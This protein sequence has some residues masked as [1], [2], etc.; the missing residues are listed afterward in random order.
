MH[1]YKL[2]C[3]FRELDLTGACERIIC[4]GTIT[5][6]RAVA[7]RSPDV[8]VGAGEL[9]TLTVPNTEPPAPERG[10]VFLEVTPAS[11]SC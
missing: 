11:A 4:Y 7:M 3:F 2:P 6:R 5:S 8:G 1:C 9:A 10:V